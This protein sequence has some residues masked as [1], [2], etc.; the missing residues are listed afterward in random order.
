MR[1]PRRSAVFDA[2]G[3]GVP[4]QERAAAGSLA[5]A[6]RVAPQDV[7]SLRFRFDG[8]VLCGEQTAADVGL[9]SGD[10]ID[11]RLI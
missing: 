8:V 5:S 3:A 6:G 4:S 11:W 2:R 10:Q 1:G 7:E 9:E